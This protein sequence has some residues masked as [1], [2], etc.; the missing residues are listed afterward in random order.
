[1]SFYNLLLNLKLKIL[2]ASAVGLLI[3]SIYLYFFPPVKEVI[4]EISIP[5]FNDKFLYG[6]DKFLNQISSS[7]FYDKIVSNLDPNSVIL[8][9]D[10][11][12]LQNAL[13]SAS[14]FKDGSS[15]LIKFDGHDEE[16]LSYLA[17]ITSKSLVIELNKNYTILKSEF[18]NINN[19]LN[20]NDLIKELKNDL[21]KKPDNLIIKLLYTHELNKI[22]DFYLKN[23]SIIINSSESEVLNIPKFNRKLYNINRIMKVVFFVILF[24]LILL[25]KE[26]NN[27]IKLF[28]NKRLIF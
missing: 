18:L 6:G 10:K 24:I 12:T 8:K 16:K 26:F 13:K 20:D 1:M 4:V 3:G 15:F 23:F 11:I 2:A 25:I 17:D 27:N 28:I 14:Y 7:F 21:N 22:S 19:Y 9:N 5:F